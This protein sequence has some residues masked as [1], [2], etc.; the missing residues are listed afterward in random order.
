[1]LGEQNYGAY[2]QIGMLRIFLFAR[3]DASQV[4]EKQGIKRSIEIGNRGLPLSLRNQAAKPPLYLRLRSNQGIWEHGNQL[5][6]PRI[7]FAMQGHFL[8]FAQP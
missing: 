2:Q 6:F 4:F 3:A 5:Q 7:R 8:T 1:M